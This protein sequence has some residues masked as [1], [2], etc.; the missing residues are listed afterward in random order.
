[1]GSRV[2]IALNI[3]SLIKGPAKKWGAEISSIL[4]TDMQ[5]APELLESMSAAAKQRRVGEFKVTAA[6]AEVQAA[7]LMGN[8]ADLMSSGTTL[9]SFEAMQTMSKLLG[10]TAIFMPSNPESSAAMMRN[11]QTNAAVGADLL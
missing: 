3:E 11:V 5:M 4:I 6:E 2:A 9:Q 8:V 7:C 1:M 10:A